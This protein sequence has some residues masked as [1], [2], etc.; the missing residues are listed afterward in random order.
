MVSGVT[1]S[2]VLVVAAGVLAISIPGEALAQGCAMCATYLS[3]NDPRTQA[4]KTSIIF[5]MI[6]PF[7]VVGSVGSWVAWMYRC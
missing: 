6:M 5:L 4:F 3:A 2:A 1:V 7:A